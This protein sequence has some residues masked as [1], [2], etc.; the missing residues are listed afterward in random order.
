MTPGK[1]GRPRKNNGQTL[2]EKFAKGDEEIIKLCLRYESSR[3]TLFRW[4]RI[5][6]TTNC[7]KRQEKSNAQIVAI[8]NQN[9][10]RTSWEKIVITAYIYFGKRR[11]YSSAWLLILTEREKNQESQQSSPSISASSSQL[12][13]TSLHSTNSQESTYA[14][15]E[16]QSGFNIDYIEPNTFGAPNTLVNYSS[17]QPTQQPEISSTSFFC[18]ESADPNNSSTTE[19]TTLQNASAK[20]IPL[21]TQT[22]NTIV[23]K[24]ASSELPSINEIWPKNNQLPLFDNFRR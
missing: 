19:C 21:T 11:R 10:A 3:K 20:S 5:L 8:Q 13:N 9:S 12:P 6:R 16:R 23:L 7:P 17:A 22:M 24:S 18:S 14:E 2:L 15:L 1:R 4:N